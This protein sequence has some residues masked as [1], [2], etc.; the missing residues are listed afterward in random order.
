MI[1]II[2]AGSR[3]YQNY[4]LLSLELDAL[5]AQMSNP[6]ITFVSGTCKGAD[7]LGE[8]YARK[9]GYP[10]V[11]FP[12]DWNRFGAAAGP[13][14]NRE[15]AEYASADGATGVLVAFWDGKSRGTRSMIQNA[16]KCGLQVRIVYMSTTRI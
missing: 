12:A 9:R 10:I 6:E 11:R 5:I 2:V 15:M 13:I 14:R 16:E 1:R 3:Y 7:I 4:D 8:N